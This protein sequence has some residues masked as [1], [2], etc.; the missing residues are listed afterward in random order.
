MYVANGNATATAANTG[1]LVT[2]TFG[3]VNAGKVRE[4]LA[5]LGYSSGGPQDPAPR[6]ALREAA[7][8][9]VYWWNRGRDTRF[10]RVFARRVNANKVDLV[11]ETITGPDGSCTRET[12]AV[13]TTEGVTGT[14]DDVCATWRRVFVHY[15]THVTSSGI[16]RWAED[17]VISTFGALAM[18]NRGHTLHIAPRR[19]AAFDAWLAGMREIA[20]TQA[21]SFATVDDDPASLASIIDA[22]R[23]SI[24]R[25]IAKEREKT[26]TT[27][28]GRDGAIARIREARERLDAYRAVA[29]D[30]VTDLERACTEAETAIMLTTLGV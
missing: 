2:F 5:R 16:G 29:A 21:I 19:A 12:V 8:Q 23:G 14:R 20:E 6:S 26:L 30:V 18:E 10:E 24:E 17:W 1:R 27:E 25:T 22:M 15:L 7:E 9:F 4:L 28:R 11:C 3:D 13:A